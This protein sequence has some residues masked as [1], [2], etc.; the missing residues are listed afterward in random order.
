MKAWLDFLPII[1]FFIA[2]KLSGIYVAAGVL[3]AAVAV[4][5]GLVWWRERKLETSQW[6]TVVATLVLGALTLGLHDEKFLQWKAPGVYVL[7]ALLF[8]GSQFIGGKPLV[9]RMMAQAVT[10]PDAQW[11]G[12]NLAWVVFF[13]FAAV[14]N[15]YVVLHFPEYW[16]D[17]KLF[18]S[19]GLT[20]LFI[21]LQGVWLVRRG[22]LNEA[23]P[24]DD[25]GATGAADAARGQRD[26]DH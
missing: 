9:Q 2:Y 3:M 8:L 20:F 13:L 6:I 11:R 21:I 16:V 1:A 22:A 17:F 12:L 23:A 26:N 10:L 5:Y 14:A 25:A 24:A 19:L 7:L 15:G 18:G 4:I